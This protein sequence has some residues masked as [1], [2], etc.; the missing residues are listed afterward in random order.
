MFGSKAESLYIISYKFD[1][2]L[3]L[4]FTKLKVEVIT[5]GLNQVKS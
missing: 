3:R 5:S 1:N 4:E 2:K